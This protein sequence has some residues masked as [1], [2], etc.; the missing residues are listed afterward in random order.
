MDTNTA[1]VVIIIAFLGLPV[2]I[3]ILKDAIVAII[4][5]LRGDE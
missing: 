2:L 4:H 3:P 1:S 5:A